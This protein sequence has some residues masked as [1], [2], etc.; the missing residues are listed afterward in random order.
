MNEREVAQ[1]L[2]TNYQPSW[3]EQIGN[4]VY[5]VARA[6]SM[7]GTANRMRNEAMNVVDFIPGVGEAVGLNDAYNDFNAGNYG[8][9]A[10]GLGATAVGAVPGVGDAVG[11][12]VKRGF[13]AFHGSP[14]DF[15]KF[16]LD[17]IGTG[18]GAQA[19]GH[20]LYFAENEDVARNYRD[21]LA[22]ADNATRNPSRAG[23]EIL[24]S[25]R[26]DKKKALHQLDWEFGVDAYP[27][28]VRNP[29]YQEAR[30]F[31]ENANPG[32]MYEVNINADPDDFLDWDAPLSEQ[33]DK[34]NE[35][36]GSRLERFLDMPGPQIESVY[37]KFISGEMTGEL[38]YKLMHP[39]SGV[40]QVD[41][42]RG[43]A[44]QASRQ[45]RDAGIPGI[46]YLDQ[47]S[48]GAGDGTRNFVVFD[49]SII[50]IVRKYG[51]AGAVSAGL[52]SAEMARQM[53]EQGIGEI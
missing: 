43:L 37:D 45:L 50:E 16:S 40:D 33:G 13:R 53:Q 17:K 7:G 6:L 30:A 46:K 9:A 52:I 44:D 20:G 19:Y 3:R 28:A 49:D 21:K 18:E 2:L 32:R 24:E 41:W 42:S 12:G 1:A 29:V 34:I 4:A 51:L 11:A 14:H 5:D 22:S 47:G 39:Q 48:R 8:L 23:M 31:I 38:A 27:Q 26:G 36:V 15:D 10:A 25:A 35:L